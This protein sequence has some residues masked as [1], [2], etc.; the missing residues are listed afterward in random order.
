M[1]STLQIHLAALER[2][3]A[4]R[5]RAGEEPKQG[6]PAATWQQPWAFAWFTFLAAPY[7]MGGICLWCHHTSS[8]FL[9]SG[10]LRKLLCW[11]LACP[12]C[13]GVCIKLV[14]RL[15]PCATWRNK[16]RLSLKTVFTSLSFSFQQLSIFLSR[17]L[18]PL[19][20][21]KKNSSTYCG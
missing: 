15:F 10:W 8:C 1:R 5:E 14:S 17:L 16:G 4:R 3:H 19:V 21:F 18:K 20:F 6:V 7:I 11:E 13:Y 12:L 2:A 9:C